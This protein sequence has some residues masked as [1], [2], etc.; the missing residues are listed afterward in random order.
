[1]AVRVQTTDVPDNRPGQ[2]SRALNRLSAVILRRY[3]A[4]APG[5]RPH[6]PIDRDAPVTEFE[7]IA[8]AYP[9]FCVVPDCQE[10]T[11]EDP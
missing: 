5:A 11:G 7:S 10:P 9:V 8:Q 2:L 4:V 6:I 3:L 1:M